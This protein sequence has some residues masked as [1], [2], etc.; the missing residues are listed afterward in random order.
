MA[1]IKRKNE[2]NVLFPYKW[3]TAINMNKLM[4]HGK[5]IKNI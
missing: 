5:K 3:I 2:K 4:Q 1:I